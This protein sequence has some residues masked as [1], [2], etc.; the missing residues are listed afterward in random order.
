[1]K[2]LAGQLKDRLR[3]SLVIATTPG[4]KK[5][6]LALAVWCPK[7]SD[8]SC[9]TL[10]AHMGAWFS[11]GVRSTVSRRPATFRGPACMSDD[12]VLFYYVI[13]YCTISY[14]ILYT[15][16]TIYDAILYYTI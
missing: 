12:I 5:Y 4:V 15:I 11:L 16:I 8:T 2:Q 10:P 13:W 7:D 6:K 14:Y 9:L 3:Q 1:M